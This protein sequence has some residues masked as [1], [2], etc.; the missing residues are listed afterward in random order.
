MKTGITYNENGIK[1]EI[2]ISAINATNPYHHR[3]IWINGRPISRKSKYYL[4]I[5]RKLGDDWL[6][7]I[8]DCWIE[9]IDINYNESDYLK[10]SNLIDKAKASKNV[11]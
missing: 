8:T 11:W 7:D 5:K 2:E 1:Y 10:L 3:K 6:S 4:D 9:K